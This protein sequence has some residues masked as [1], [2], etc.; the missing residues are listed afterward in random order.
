MILNKENIIYLKKKNKKLLNNNDILSIVPK[1][2]IDNETNILE[3]LNQKKNK[4]KL[5]K[6]KVKEKKK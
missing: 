6:I 3:S 2:K 1:I 4:K 5:K